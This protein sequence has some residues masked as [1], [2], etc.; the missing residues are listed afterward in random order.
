VYEKIEIDGIDVYYNKNR[1]IIPYQ[2]I[3]C[4]W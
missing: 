1:K 3:G 2:D 4:Y